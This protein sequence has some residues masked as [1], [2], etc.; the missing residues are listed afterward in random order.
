M[1]TTEKKNELRNA[2]AC[3][4]YKKNSV[5]VAETRRKQWRVTRKMSSMTKACS[6]KNRNGKGNLNG[7]LSQMQRQKQS[8]GGESCRK[9]N[10]GQEKAAD[11]YE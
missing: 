4:L 8:M 10:A 7:C 9:K 3:H 5:P 11:E 6:K 2:A 1:T